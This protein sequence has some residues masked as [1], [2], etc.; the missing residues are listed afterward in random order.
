M[1]LP[2]NSQALIAA[3]TF[4]IVFQAGAGAFFLYISGQG[5]KIFRDGLRL[6]LITFISSSVLWSQISFSA[7]LIEPSAAVGCQVAVISA[8]LFDQLA[9]FAIEQYLLWAINSGLK[10]APD[11]FVPQALLVIRGIVGGIFVGFQRPQ[12]FPVCQTSNN[13]SAVGIAV[14]ASDAVIILIF[15]ARV[16]MI[17]L[18]QDVREKRPGFQRSKAVI[19]LLA[20]LALWTGTSVPMFLGI[21]TIDLIWRTALPAG[22]LSILLGK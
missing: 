1:S 5:K 3:F 10:K 8:S 17:G 2:A 12:L 22:A 11:T 4:G 7:T 14:A 18:V 9:R 20:G 15:V 21:Q 13:A 6:A 19:F 16:F